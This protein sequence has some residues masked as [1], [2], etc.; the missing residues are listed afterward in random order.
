[1]SM[2]I[3]SKGFS[4]AVLCRDNQQFNEQKVVAIAA[5]ET[6]REAPFE[7]KD[8][9][10]TKNGDELKITVYSSARPVRTS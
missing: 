6:G 7:A 3:H 4:F 9:R 8:F 1:M 10:Y 2:K 5:E